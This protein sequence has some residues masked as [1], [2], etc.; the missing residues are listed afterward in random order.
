ME[1]CYEG[2]ENIRRLREL[3]FFS[4]RNIKEFDDWALDRV[5]GSE[6]EKLE[7]LDVSGTNITAN[8]LV[9]VLKLPSL[10]MLFLDNVK[11]STEFEYTVCLLQEEMPR[12]ECRDINELQKVSNETEKPK[13]M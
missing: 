13:L 11:R 5:C 12:L 6:F 3:T 9:A 10:R 8:G 2:L 7:V 1:L 4:L